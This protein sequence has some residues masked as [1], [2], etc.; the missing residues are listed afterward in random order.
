MQKAFNLIT[1]F[2][3]KEKSPVIEILGATASGK[4]DFSIQVAQF[5]AE[6]LNKKSEIISVDSRQIYKGIDVSSGK[7][8]EEE[9]MG[10]P[11]HGLDMLDPDQAYSVYE[12]QQY[13]FATIEDIFARGAI[14]ILC[15]GTMLWLDS[16]SENYVFSQDGSKSTQK[17][18]PRYDF[19]KLG[20]A[21]DRE[22]LYERINFRTKIL[23]NEGL[24]EEAQKMQALNICKSAK[25]SLGFEEVEAFLKGEIT[26]EEALARYQKLNRNYAKRQLTWWR[27]RE[28]IHWVS[29]NNA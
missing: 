1:K 22:K 6:K 11:H 25:T 24:I 2:V 20:M 26:R 23:F 27:G 13:A 15:G 14:P 4:T 19:L 28:D 12:F 10:I 9:K 21:W 16:I 8:T 29:L 7:I 18:E 17:S 5:L 3:Q